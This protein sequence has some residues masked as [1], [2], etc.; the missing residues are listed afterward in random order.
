MRD[1]SER[2][3]LYSEDEIASILKRSARLQAEGEVESTAGLTLSELK[4][5]ASEV[6]IDP[7]LV[8]SAT[9]DLERG[10]R[11]DGE[12]ASSLFLPLKS[13]ESHL[14]RGEVRATRWEDVLA[15]IRALYGEFGSVGQ[16]GNQLNWVH[17]KF[18]EPDIQVSVAS[19]NGRTKVSAS[20]DYSNLL[21]FFMPG[22]FASSAVV[23]ALTIEG[24]G[25][26]GGAVALALGLWL[27]VYWLAARAILARLNRKEKRRA[28]ALTDRLETILYDDRE[29][30]G[31]RQ[32]EQR[33]DEV[34]LNKEERTDQHPTG[35][36]RDRA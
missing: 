5:I 21:A 26:T 29:R 28:R 22:M 14:V 25:L 13:R 20:S 6:G 11:E 31:A 7:A 4:H 9:R 24:L 35:R 12:K 17:S 3:R 2:E 36:R 1:R 15:E 16:V 18:P 23:A 10:L 27:T 33:I 32:P 34:S 30:A 8:E 19:R